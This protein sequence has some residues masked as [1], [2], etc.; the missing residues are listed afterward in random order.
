MKL[1]GYGSSPIDQ[2]AESVGRP[3]TPVGSST[4]AAASSSS[5]ADAATPAAPAASDQVH[6]SGDAELLKAALQGIDKAP[7]VRQD[8]VDRTRKAIQDGTLV[9][10]PAQIADSL[11]NHWLQD[12]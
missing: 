10:D 5:S 2:S 11:I 6:L 4:P 9:N 7:A 12:F 8:V 3:S 1:D